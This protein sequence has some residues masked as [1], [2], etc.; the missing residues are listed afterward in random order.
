M[1]DLYQEILVKKKPTPT[2]LL[3][4]TALIALVVLIAAAGIL[5]M[6]LLLP[7]AVILGLLLWW[8]VLPRFDVEYEYLYVN[9][10][11]DIDAIYAKQKRKRI[12]GYDLHD[13]EMLAPEGSHALDSYVNRQGV[14]IK[15]FSSGEEK[16]KKYV[17][18][19]NTDKT[20]EII[21]LELNSEILEDVRRIAPR[22][23]SLM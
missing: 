13:I 6:P 21:R 4:K 5:I 19:I 11:L 18:V 7:V 20:Q 12:A 8:L 14:K 17:A 15:D 9:G 22:R 3:A 23:V 1:N 2:D 16:A 10:E